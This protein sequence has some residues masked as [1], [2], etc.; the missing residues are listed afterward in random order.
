MHHEWFLQNLGKEAV[1][2]NMYTTVA[3][4]LDLKKALVNNY[5]KRKE[6]MTL[7]F[8]TIWYLMRSLSAIDNLRCVCF[9]IL[10][11][12]RNNMAALAF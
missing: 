12:I 11:K 5:G 7:E 8:Q 9:Q 1:E 2:S 10:G 4:F 3:R 6:R